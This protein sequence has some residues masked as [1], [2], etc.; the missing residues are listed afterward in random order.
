MMK[1]ELVFAYGSNM[2]PAQMRE[3]CPESDLWWFIAE[4]RDWK[5]YFPRKSNQ[6]R[7]GVGSI[8]KQVGSSVWGVVFAVSEH[9]LAR[10][11]RYEGSAPTLT[12]EIWWTYSTREDD[13]LLPGPTSQFLM[14]RRNIDHIE[15]T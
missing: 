8:T 15:T 5:L 14:V 11:D 6:R 2:D 3:R 1:S 4:A 9:D 10:L 7:G 12:D 13:I